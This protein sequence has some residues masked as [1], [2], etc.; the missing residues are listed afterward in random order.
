MATLKEVIKKIISKDD[1][2]TWDLQKWAYE[3]T[4]AEKMKVSKK[5]P[6]GMKSGTMKMALPTEVQPLDKN[7]MYCIEEFA[8]FVVAIPRKILREELKDM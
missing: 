5:Y 6:D 2:L 7:C 3:F 1:T 4:S 8:I